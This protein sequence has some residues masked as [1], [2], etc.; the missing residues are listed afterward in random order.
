MCVFIIISSDENE[1]KEFI[2]LEEKGAKGERGERG[3]GEEGEGGE[4]GEGGERGGEGGGRGEEKGKE[5]EAN[6]IGCRTEE[7]PHHHSAKTLLF[8]FIKF[9]F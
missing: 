7:E 9:V 2:R 8:I 5:K 1:V 3:G 4:G 6:R